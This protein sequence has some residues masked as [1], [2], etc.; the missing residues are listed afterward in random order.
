MLPDQ[1]RIPCS[2]LKRKFFPAVS[3]A[4]AGFSLAKRWVAF[5]IISIEDVGKK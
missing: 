1:A 3:S 2:P 4:K 5:N